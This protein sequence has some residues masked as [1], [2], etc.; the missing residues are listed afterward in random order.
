MLLEYG[1]AVDELSAH[2]GT[3]SPYLMLVSRMAGICASHPEIREAHF[4]RQ[5][6]ESL[7]V[8]IEF[9]GRLTALYHDRYRLAQPATPEQLREAMQGM[10]A[11]AVD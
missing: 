10:A 4:F 5:D 6:L 3:F 7:P 8:L 9:F 2:F 1:A 11:P